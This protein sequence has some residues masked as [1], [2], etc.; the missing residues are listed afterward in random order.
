L[1]LSQQDAAQELLRR[2]EARKSLLRFTEYTFP[3]YRAGR[4]HELVAT[5]LDRVVSG[6][7]KRLMLFAPPQHGKTEL[8]SVRLP[9]YWLGHYPDDPIILTS[10]AANLAFTNSKKARGV[11]ESQAYGNLF[12]GTQITQEAR[13][14]EQWRIADH[15]GVLV[16]AGVGGP[17]TGHGARL[18]IIDDPI[19]NWEEAQSDAHR[20]S[21]WQWW[22][23]TFR[24][25]VWE[26]GAIVLIMTRWHTDDL[27][28]RILEQ[29]EGE[30][31]VLRFPAVA[32]ETPDPLGRSIGE[33]LCPGRFSLDALDKTKRDIGSYAWAAEYQGR[34][35]PIEGSLAKRQW[36]PIVGAVPQPVEDR[37]RAWDFAATE[38]KSA[39]SDP[40]YTV[41]TL[42][43]LS[44]GAYYVEHVIR[45]RAGPGEVEAL[46]KRTAHADGVD[47]RIHLE[48]EPGSSGKL[49]VR[50]L[51]AQLAGYAARATA[52][53]GDKITRA[54]PFLAQAEAQNVKLVRGAW[55]SAWLDE[56]TAVP[57]AAHDDQWDSAAAA[58]QAVVSLNRQI[59]TM[60]SLYGDWGREEP[61]MPH[62]RDASVHN[63][64][65]RHKRW[66]KKHFCAECYKEAC[67]ARGED[68]SQR[69]ILWG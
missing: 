61:L 43:A 68:A 14:T 37:V 12:P 15:R 25:R 55:N 24:P 54:M 28:A 34:P 49:F 9:A 62:E 36:F 65:E 13:A 17:I 58:F 40:D 11:V 1:P 44:G 18:A 21:V 33:P 60:P 4:F 67:E 69:P 5:T 7:V 56:I 29:N 22:R 38:K 16:A 48:Q 8:V 63:D 59:Q 66:A 64:S 3:K 39:K 20:H 35:K 51:I 10:Y 57:N 31:L 47:V 42:M 23:T 27:A 32:D 30:W 41:G 19:K 46:V 53:T 50:A 45:E 52:P 26:D 6:D 2:R